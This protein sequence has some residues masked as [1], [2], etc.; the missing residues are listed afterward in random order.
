LVKVK[1][2]EADKF[3]VREGTVC[4]ADEAFENT[5]YSAITMPDGIRAIGKQA[6]ANCRELT[7]IALPEGIS[8]IAERTFIGCKKLEYVSIPEGVVTVGK[9]AFYGVKNGMKMD[10]PVSVTNVGVE[11]FV[12]YFPEDA[13]GE[14]F[15]VYYRGDVSQWSSVSFEYG[16]E[17]L[18]GVYIEKDVRRRT[19]TGDVAGDGVISAADAHLLKQYMTGSVDDSHINYAAA[20]IN[21]DCMVN[22]RDQIMLKRMIVGV[23]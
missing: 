11:A 1:D 17:W 22:A 23:E 6:F 5:S 14:M 7:C 9:R 2:S 3:S 12:P 13:V 4:I 18:T 16:N 21:R 10:F 15:T 20:D 19:K 8:E